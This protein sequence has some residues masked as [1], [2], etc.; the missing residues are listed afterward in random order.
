[1]K[2]KIFDAHC[3]T[4]LKLE[5][6]EYFLSGGSKSLHVDLPTLLESGVHDQVMAICVAPHKDNAEQMWNMGIEN[7]RKFNIAERPNLH[8]ALEGCTPIYFNWKLPYHPIVASL[9]WNGDNPYAGGIGSDM[10][11]TDDGKK[12]V[13]RF[14]KEETAI[15]VSHL[16]DRSRES[17]LKL[18]KPVCAT[19]CNARSLCL[20]KKRNLP[21]ADLCEI[22]SLGGV[23]GVTFVPYFLENNISDVTIESIVNHIEY[24]AEKT[25]INSVGFGSDFDGV[26]DLPRGITG[27]ESWYRVID[28]LE[29]RGW[30]NEDI[31]K[32]A[33]DNWRNFF[34]F[35]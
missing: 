14:Y 34:K 6:A 15:D 30:S 13:E 32:I 8:F 33:G 17:V 28:S 35:T 24:I 5:A 11:L 18:G 3:D 31:N 12:L 20:G 4:L 26:K 25:S 23:I 21:D 2:R 29:N 1:M 22:A 16:N 10:D 9:T 7:F 19:H 27:A